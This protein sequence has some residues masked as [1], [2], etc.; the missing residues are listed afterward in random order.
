MGRFDDFLKLIANGLRSVFIH[1][2]GG[3][4]KSSI[5]KQ[6]MYRHLD[7]RRY[8]VV[9]WFYADEREKFNTLFIHLTRQL[10]IPFEETSAHMAVLHWIN[11]HGEPG[12]I[13]VV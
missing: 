7:T 5:A 6:Y 1:G 11:N 8:Q 13:L 10:D 9:L 4:G 12:P 3:C 2:L